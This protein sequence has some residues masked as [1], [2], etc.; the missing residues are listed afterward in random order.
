MAFTYRQKV[1]E[2]NTELS[3][4]KRVYSRLVADGKMKQSTADVRMNILAAIISEDI[5]PKA[6]E[7][8]KAAAAEAEQR[9]PKLL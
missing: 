5:G 4:R 6:D 8:R 1:Q 2:L 9:E 7:E 3:Y